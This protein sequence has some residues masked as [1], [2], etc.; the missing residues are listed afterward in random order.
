MTQ[1]QHLPAPGGDNRPRTKV[2]VIGSGLAGLTASHLLNNE[3]VEVHL[4]ERASALGMDSESITIPGLGKRVTVPMRSYQGGYYPRLIELYKRIGVVSRETDYTYSFSR[5]ARSPQGD[6]ITTKFIYNGASGR[7]GVNTP[8][9]RHQ[10]ASKSLMETLSIWAA[11]YVYLFFTAAC[12]LRMV[13]L[14][15]PACRST[16]VETMTFSQWVEETRPSSLLSKWLG[17][18]ARWNM[19]VRDILLPLFSGVLS[20]ETKEVLEHPVEEFLD[21][22]WL[23]FGTH[24]YIVEK[25]V[26]D[27]VDR[28][29][30]NFR[31]VHLSSTIVAIRPDTEDAGL[32]QVVVE[33]ADGQQQ[34]Y[35]GFRHII[36][37]TTAPQAGNILSQYISALPS[38]DEVYRPAIERLKSCL[39]LFRTC[40]AIIVNHTDNSLVPRDSQDRRE[41]NV[42][43]LDEAYPLPELKSDLRNCVE[44]SCAMA[45]QILPGFPS[46]RLVYQTT[47]PVIPIPE[48]SILSVSRMHRAL[49]TSQ[50]KKALKGIYVREKVAGAPWYSFT[51]IQKGA[52]GPL[53]GAGYRSSG[54]KRSVGPGIWVCGAYACSGIPFLEGCVVSAELVVE[55]ILQSNA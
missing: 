18:D 6:D 41:L 21:Y 19:F 22:T 35:G 17:L 10:L 3:D 26:E 16:Q 44:R 5:L 29:S 11:H 33:R 15:I 32:A 42:V 36:L 25:G 30:A 14:S 50:S 20:C 51:P 49:L 37:A 55:A 38:N 2:A 39:G 13:L 12:F 46:D 48:K 9:N 28:I 8:S 7:S 34:V 43:T 4:F 52:L 53:Q 40:E 27:V 45:T 31:N 24:Q 1:P 54:E 47:N 23:T